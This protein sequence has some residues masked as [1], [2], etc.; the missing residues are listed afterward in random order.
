VVLTLIQ[1]HILK[2]L[3]SSS[4]AVRLLQIDLSKAF[5]KTVHNIAL[6]ALARLKIS[7]EAYLWIK[8][9]LSNRLQRVR[10][11]E[12]CSDWYFAPSGVPQGS[13]LGP[14]IFAAVVN[15][16][17][18]LCANSKLYKYADDLTLLHF[19][20]Q[21][22][23]D[24]L[25]SEMN[26]ISA[27]SDA[28][29]LPINYKKSVVVDIITKRSLHIGP[30]VSPVDGSIIPQES[31]SKL[32]G[33]TISSDL[34]WDAHFVNTLKKASRRIYIL[35][36]MKRCGATKDWLWRVYLSHIRSVLTYAAAATCNI[37]NKIW[38]ELLQI[39]KRV[40]KIIGSS[41][42]IGI[43]EFVENHCRTLAKRSIDN[44]QHP[45]HPLFL[46]APGRSGGRH[47][48]NRAPIAYTTRYQQSFIRFGNSV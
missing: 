5:D 7:Q 34:K 9:F 4:G 11:G 42:P 18:P 30:L 26:H 48:H 46:K 20:R 15:D 24:S 28:T 1:H 32:L 21:I 31:T 22:I 23:D 12:N 47:G 45:L 33:L 25:Q 41:P 35:V 17:A 13:V 40:Q 44:E 39:E 10:M 38:L 8:S 14:I 37:P 27:W 16:L 43:Q 2:H 6:D 36:H 3:D 29:L 19:I